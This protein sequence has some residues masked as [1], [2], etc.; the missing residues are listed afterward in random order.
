LGCGQADALPHRV[1]IAFEPPGLVVE[2]GLEYAVSLAVE[3]GALPCQ[4]ALAV[5]VPAQV[6]VDADGFGEEYRFAPPSGRVLGGDD[7]LTGPGVA[8]VRGREPESAAVE[9]QRRAVDTA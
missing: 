7:G 2:A 3:H 6:R 1:R 5:L 8:D 4:V 9:S